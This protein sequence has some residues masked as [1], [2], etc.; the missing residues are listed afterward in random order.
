MNF[1]HNRVVAINLDSDA[2]TEFFGIVAVLAFVSTAIWIIITLARDAAQK[3]TVLEAT[4]FTEIAK[5]EQQHQEEAAFEEEVRR[6]QEEYVEFYEEIVRSSKTKLGELVAHSRCAYEK[7][8]TAYSRICHNPESEHPENLKK[9][10]TRVCDSQWNFF[11]A[12]VGYIGYEEIEPQIAMVLNAQSLFEQFDHNEDMG[13]MTMTPG[14]AR[15]QEVLLLQKSVPSERMGTFQMD[16]IE[17][18]QPFKFYFDRVVKEWIADNVFKIVGKIRKKGAAG[19]TIRDTDLKERFVRMKNTL[20]T[21]GK[22][23]DRLDSNLQNIGEED[24]A[25]NQIMFAG[26]VLSMLSS[27]PD[28]FPELGDTAAEE[29]EAVTVAEEETEMVSSESKYSSSYK[30]AD[31]SGFSPHPADR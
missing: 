2:F 27:A 25:F 18:V 12:E 26:V 28:W 15:V 5:E 13:D 11:K 10:F 8:A 7:M 16:V 17:A 23:C 30:S 1:I 31:Q 20:D 3:K 9:R 24:A 6:I 21:V 4:S 14:M 29:E 22:S 19:A